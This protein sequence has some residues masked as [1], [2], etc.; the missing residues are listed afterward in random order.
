MLQ[1]STPQPPPT[2]QLEH[3]LLRTCLL[4]APLPVTV[5]AGQPQFRSILGASLSTSMSAAIP[6]SS[7]LEDMTWAPRGIAPGSSRASYC[8]TMPLTAALGWSARLG[9]RMNSAQAEEAGTAWL[10]DLL[11][12]VTPSACLPAHILKYQTHLALCEPLCRSSGATTQG[13]SAEQRPSCDHTHPCRPR[14]SLLLWKIS[15]A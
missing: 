15:P 2:Q 14:Q 12:P 7:A 1:L 3:C 5:L 8:T 4:P 13:C 6:S 10:H 11:T 9:M